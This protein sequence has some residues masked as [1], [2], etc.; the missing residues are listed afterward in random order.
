MKI[1]FES[2]NK[3]RIISI[4]TWIVINPFTYPLVSRYLRKHG[5]NVST[6]TLRKIIKA[7]KKFKKEHVEWN[8]IDIESSTGNIMHIQI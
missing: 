1:T 8:A 6:K 4:P 7:H 3:Q 2:E 5:I